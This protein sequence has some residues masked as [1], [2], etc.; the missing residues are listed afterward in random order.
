V[1][2]EWWTKWPNANVGVACG[3]SSGVIVLDRDDRHG[4][5]DS[6]YELEREHGTPCDNSWRCATANGGVH[7]YFRAPSFTVRNA[8]ALWPGLDIRG[9]GGYV[10][11]PPS[12][13]D[14]E[15]LYRWQVGFAP[16][17]LLLA[18]A[19]EWLLER[20]RSDDRHG[21]GHSPDFWRRLGKLCAGQCAE[22]NA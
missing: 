2:A 14:G 1:I 7:L 19:P 10:V 16:H 5:D 17:E 3:A 12:V 21:T 11:A 4:G 13:L 8:V 6:L 22:A 9:E 18:D 15:R 20:L